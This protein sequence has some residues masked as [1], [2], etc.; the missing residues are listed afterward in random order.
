M[1]HNL[2]T[3]D[4]T[5]EQICELG[6]TIGHLLS[7]AD[8]EV[9]AKTWEE[10]DSELLK[11]DVKNFYI[12]ADYH[13]DNQDC[14]KKY[15]NLMLNNRSSY[16]NFAESYSGVVDIH[17]R[18]PSV[19]EENLFK[20]LVKDYYEE[21]GSVESCGKLEDYLTELYT[22][23]IFVFIFDVIE[24]TTWIVGILHEG[25]GDFL[26]SKLDSDCLMIDEFGL[27]DVMKWSE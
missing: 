21:E 3:L 2:V 12:E 18:F 19:F 11:Q 5:L 27:H 24:D 13:L 16:I 10:E 14:F 6:G 23:C 1:N 20:K 26:K 25:F 22:M 17:T 9:I 8:L 7:L 15:L 4:K